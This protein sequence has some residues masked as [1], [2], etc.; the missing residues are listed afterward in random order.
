MKTQLHVILT[1]LIFSFFIPKSILRAQTLPSSVVMKDIDGGTFTM[2]S[3]NLT[4][5]PDQKE[6]A[7]EHEVTL[8]AINLILCSFQLVF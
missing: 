3:N 2:G 7:S 1:L 5:N 8:T 4:G 6:A